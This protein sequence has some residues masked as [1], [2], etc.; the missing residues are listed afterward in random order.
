ME[1]ING[2]WIFRII[3]KILIPVTFWV[4]ATFPG[5]Y[6]I[7]GVMTILTLAYYVLQGVNI[8]EEKYIK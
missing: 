6:W 7:A 8:G 1:K 2:Y 5:T 4:V 3:I